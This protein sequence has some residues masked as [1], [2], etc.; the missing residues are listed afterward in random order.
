MKA[1]IINFFNTL[2]KVQFAFLG[3]DLG[4]TTLI[5]LITYYL[6]IKYSRIFY[7]LELIIL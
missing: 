5:T 1:K 3:N 6:L 2:A 7:I 4:K